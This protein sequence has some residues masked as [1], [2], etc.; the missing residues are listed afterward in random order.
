MAW[1]VYT[2]FDAGGEVIYAGMSGN[3]EGRIA[4]H[5]HI[6]PW[7]GEV[8]SVRKVEFLTER[9][10]RDAEYSIIAAETPKHND[11]GRDV[12]PRCKTATR[13]NNRKSGYCTPCFRT[14]MEERRRSLGVKPTP[15]PTITCPRCGGIKKPGPSYC[16]D[17]K[18]D[19]NKLYRKNKS[20]RN[21]S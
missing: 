3:I 20:A 4:K 7:F 11:R 8:A 19:V 13:G 1:T 12:C 2:F 15:P 6:R 18:K 9:D 16:R 14:Y 10:A 5:R 21:L 17:C